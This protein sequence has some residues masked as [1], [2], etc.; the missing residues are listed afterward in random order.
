MLPVVLSGL[1]LILNFLEETYFFHLHAYLPAWFYQIHLKFP[2]SRIYFQ[3]DELCSNAN[4][5]VS[6]EMLWQIYDLEPV[7]LQEIPIKACITF[8]N[9]EIC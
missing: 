9:I 2:R 3:L 7:E 5:S 6:Q 4:L 8:Y 1:V